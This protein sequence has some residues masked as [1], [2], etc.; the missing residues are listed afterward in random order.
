MDDKA[1]MGDVEMGNVELHNRDQWQALVTTVIILYICNT[2]TI[3]SLVIALIF[4]KLQ[5]V[6]CLFRD[7]QLFKKLVDVSIDD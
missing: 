1:C 6:S 7:Y 2:H 3:I 5:R 4:H